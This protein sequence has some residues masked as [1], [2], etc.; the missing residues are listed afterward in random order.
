[1]FGRLLGLETKDR[2]SPSIAVAVYTALQGA[3]ILRVHDVFETKKAIEIAALL[4][5]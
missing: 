5:E 2:L 3:H 1:M 4:S